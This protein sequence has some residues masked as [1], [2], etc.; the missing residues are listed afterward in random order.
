[1]TLVVQLSLKALELLRNGLHP[2]SGATL[3]ASIDFNETNI[4]GFITAST[5]D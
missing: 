3:F 1:M 2:R 4:A 5:Q